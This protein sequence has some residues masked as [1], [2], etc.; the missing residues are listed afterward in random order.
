MR[1]RIVLFFFIGFLLILVSCGTAKS[2]H[3]KPDLSTYN[4]AVPVVTKLSDSAF[5]SGKNSFLKNK[6][7]LWELYAEGDPLEIGLNTGA[8]TDSLLKKQQ[9]I[10]FSK[11]TDIVPSKFQQKLLRS[12]LKWY[13]RK[14]Y[15]NVTNEYQAEIYG[16]SEYTSH[17][18]DNIGPQYQRSLYL[19]AAHDLGH[20]LQDLALVGCSSFA[21][22]GEKSEDGNLILGRNFDFYVN[23]AFAENKIAAF[24]NPKEGHPFMMVTWP[25]MIGAVSGMNLEGI[26]VTINA[27]KSEIPLTAKTP[28][29]ILTREILQYAKNLDEAVSIAKKRKVFVSESIMVGSANDNKAILI[30]VSP[31]KMDVYDVPNTSQLICSNHFQGEAFKNDE[32]NQAQIDNSHSKYRYERM[33]ELLSENP[34]V[35]PKIASEILRNKEGLQNIALGYGN[36]KALNQL[37]AHHGVI[38]KPKEK[39]VWVSANPY[40]LG[41]FVCYNLDTVFKQKKVNP[42]ISLEEENLNIAKDPFIKTT[43]FLKYQKF[44]IEDHKI[45]LYLKNK[46]EIPTDFIQNYQ[47]LNP[48]YWVVYYKAGLY[49][50][51]IKQYQLAQENF[52][53]ALTKEITTVPD[54]EA[55]E[56]YLKKLKRK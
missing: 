42:A 32:R 52:E 56:K 53:K 35:N 17:E 23:D 15:L 9:Q 50:Y 20:A 6:Q 7:G 21:A 13:N 29:S 51:Q 38:F 2:A 25:G 40:Q 46:T 41:E 33:Q 43:A 28:I 54:K 1:N 18:F 48:D 44:R 19:H 5:I 37:M 14:L 11:I 10:F 55:I 22:W 49:F 31:E 39:L 36:E 16:L 26:T 45:D 27:S 3:H 4:N 24:I 34:K 8:L 47:S 30:E 12:F